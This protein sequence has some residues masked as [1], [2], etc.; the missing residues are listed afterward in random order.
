MRTVVA[1]EPAQKAGGCFETVHSNYACR[2]AARTASLRILY[3]P[4]MFISL[5][6]CLRTLG[7]PDARCP[8]A[9]QE[10][11][12]E[13]KGSAHE[14]LLQ[15]ASAAEEAGRQVPLCCGSGARWLDSLAG[16]LH[17]IRVVRI[18]SLVYG[19]LYF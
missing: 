14:A 7:K 9:A 10:G 19:V 17:I 13:S 1:R 5:V 16:D 2:I 18:L 12:N 3:E 8:G 15:F 4:R 11:G 6:S